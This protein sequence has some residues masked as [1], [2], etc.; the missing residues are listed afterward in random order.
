MISKKMIAEE[1]L[2]ATLSMILR[3]STKKDKLCAVT[4]LLRDAITAVDEIVRKEH[5]Q[6][7]LCNLVSDNNNDNDNLENDDM[8]L[9]F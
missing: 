9:T 2:D 7:R 6:L 5:Q 1:N 3:I 4:P 8:Q